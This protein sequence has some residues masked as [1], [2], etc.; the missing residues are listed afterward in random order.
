MKRIGYLVLFSL[1][2]SHSLLFSQ[3]DYSKTKTLMLISNA[4]FDTQWRWTVQASIDE[5]LK[6]TLHQN[7]DLF[8]KYPYYNF[9][10]EGAIKYM[11]AKE[12]YP[13]DYD[14]LKN[15]I[16]AGRWNICGSSLDAGDANIP[17]PEAVI[18]NILIGQNFYKK[19]FGKN[20]RDIF[21]PDCFGFGYA[22]PSIA[23]HCGLK[24]FS[25]QKLT[26]GSAFGVPFNVGYWQG[27]DGSR[28][29]AVL[30]AQNYTRKLQEDYS[31]KQ[32]CIDLVEQ[33][34]EK[35]GQYLSYMYYGVGDRGGSP[36]EESVQWL[37]KS[38][39]GKGPLKVVAAPADLLCRE[40]TPAK[41]AKFS[42]YN[43]ELL[44]TY[45]GAGC[46]TSQSAMKRWNRK[47]ELL[48]DASEK[49]SVIA[50][51]L[52][53]AKYPK[54]RI[55][56]AWVRFAW[57][58]FHDDLTGTSIFDVYGFSWNDEIIATN[59]FAGILEDA[60]GGAIRALET[61]ATGTPVVV[62]N[63]LSFER[64]DVVTA[65]INKE[66]KSA[67]VLDPSFSEVPSQ[68]LR[69]E[70]GR[71]TVVFL[72]K[73]P[74]IGFA[75]YDVQTFDYEADG[76]VKNSLKI[77]TDFIE[78]NRYKISIDANGDVSGILDKVN[79]KELLSAP[80]RMQMLNDTSNVYPAWEIFY[81]AV[82]AA[83]R[84]FVD[85][86]V[87]VEITEQGPV[88]ASLKITRRKENSVFVQFIRLGA[89]SGRIEFENEVQWNTKNTLLKAAFPF[90]M[91]NEKATYDLGFGT[92][93]RGNNTEKLY[94]VPA[95]QWADITDKSGTYGVSILSD[96]KYGWDKPAD[97][98]L[99]LTLF[100]TAVTS[101]GFKDQEMIDIGKHNFGYAICG[102]AGDWRNNTIQQ[103]ACFNQPLIAFE[104]KPFDGMMGRT[105]SF[106]SLNTKQVI[107]RALKKAENS[108]EIV[109][110][111]QELNG[112]DA[113]NV[114]VKFPMRITAAREINGAE[115]PIAKVPLRD[116][117]LILNFKPYQP[118]TFAITLAPSYE[119][120]SPAQ[121]IDLGLD[122]NIDVVSS[123]SSRDDGN[124]ID[125][126]TLPSEQFP[127]VIEFKGIKFK[128]GLKEDGHAN[129]MTCK[130]D[131]ITI[132]NIQFRTIYF[133]AASRK[134]DIPTS[135]KVDGKTYPVYIQSMF[136]NVGQWDKSTF[137]STS[138]NDEKIE[139][140]SQENSYIKRENI[141]WYA[142]H[143]H[144]GFANE[145]V[146]YKFGYVFCYKINIP[147]NAKELVLPN[148]EDIIVFAISMGK[149]YN[150][151]VVP[152]RDLYDRADVVP[153]VKYT[154]STN[155]NAFENKIAVT[156]F[157]QR[158]G[159]VIHYTADGST[160]DENS[161]V[162]GSTLTFDKTTILKAKAFMPGSETGY[163]ICVPFIKG[164][165]MPAINYNK[166]TPGLEV[167][168]Y[169]GAWKKV[170]LFDTMKSL[171]IL[172][173]DNFHIPKFYFGKDN[174]GLRFKGYIQLPSDG[175]YNIY[176]QSDDGSLLYIDGKN[177]INNDG[178]HAGDEVTGSIMLKKGLHT[179]ALDYFEAAYG[180]ELF[181]QI[182]GPGMKKQPIPPSM[183]FRKK[184]EE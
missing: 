12:Y 32:E 172:S 76:P 167:S 93:Q 57:H 44:M 104:S 110:R 39:E 96:C 133:L 113:A 55:S 70:N 34:G 30:D 175:F 142:T 13:A 146:S 84:S 100:H 118:R 145:N 108:N 134:G 126:K 42:V 152:A 95:Q 89:N 122:Y 72:A 59:Q 4:H 74:S 176:L 179:I 163:E 155:G 66:C 114:K 183:L 18:R 184:T 82:S 24:G 63:P 54:E 135:F 35:T 56:D 31:N 112:K 101:G 5:Y 91:S 15:Y 67:K 40:M 177:I 182:E 102:H 16:A 99:R 68:I 88:R 8:R 158:P 94:E 51:W 26:W 81:K 38:I 71:T 33:M 46:Y 125:A 116:T 86:N 17:S 14:T 153:Q 170:P 79:K 127:S 78:N 92:I 80:V 117:V 154:T 136:E 48:A 164:S 37:G 166:I 150:E 28:L 61:R 140:F 157:T 105:L 165:C 45:H 121:S 137:V 87:K 160:P 77:S 149:N 106:V 168:I 29:I 53:S 144:N 156:L 148:D 129:A 64:E 162:Y 65:T 115:E 123:D 11:W 151:W 169:E 120:V 161:P 75:V 139:Y 107:V 97:N 50:D 47:N 62:Y 69:V 143:L 52:G 111:L 27:V 173:I 83:P 119:K 6:N 181:I 178:V 141:A 85:E 3:T 60:C 43:G 22:L 131:K 180:E 25:T 159:Q 98:M 7:F 171:D 130:G 9:N 128:M 103:A 73:V 90:K 36:T 10:F 58:Q 124:I 41:A 132:P 21:L 20:S 2:W 1:L 109:I 49:A 19:E 147:E 23:A 138:I 174:F